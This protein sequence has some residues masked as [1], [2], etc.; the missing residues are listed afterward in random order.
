[1]ANTDPDT[2]M[3]RG[4]GETRE[5]LSS[6]DSAGGFPGHQLDRHLPGHS[7]PRNKEAAIKQQ[8]NN[9]AR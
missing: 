8:T 2:G 6:I 1:M 7:A 5:P 4:P 3:M 9:R